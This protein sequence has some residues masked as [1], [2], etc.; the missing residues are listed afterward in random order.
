MERCEQ[1]LPEEVLARA[2]LVGSEY[3]WPLT[4]IPMVIEAAKIANL[5]NIGGQLQFRGPEIGIWECYWVEVDT[6]KEID[7]N[8][9]WTERVSAAAN[10]ALSQFKHICAKYDFIAEVR[11]GF[12][13]HLAA[14]EA[15]GGN[16]DKAL[17]FVW[18]VEGQHGRTLSAK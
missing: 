1:L 17:C 16:V 13:K 8:L 18:Y 15:Q 12:A 9:P 7:P 10:V 14:F 11:S 6:Y 4:D 2:T 3:A 5:L